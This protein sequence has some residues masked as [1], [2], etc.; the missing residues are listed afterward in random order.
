MTRREKHLAFAGVLTVLF[1][2]SLNMTVVGTALP[3]IIAELEGFNLYAW[4]FTSF[5]L[6]STVSLPIYGRLSDIYGRKGILL[7]GIVVFALASVLSGL[8]QDMLQL[9]AFRALQGVGGGALMS[10]AFATIADIFTPRE[11][12]RYQGFNGA[13]FGVSSVIGPVVGGLITDSLGWRWV[14]FV[15]VPVAVVAFIVITRFL[16]RAE[17][18]RGHAIDFVGSLLLIAGMVPLLLALTW[19]GVDYPWSSPVVVGLLVGAGLALGLFGW[20]QTRT[21]SP[22]L[23]PELFRNATFNIANLAGFMTGVGMFGA[24]IYLPL[25]VQGVQAGS[26]AESG[27]ALAPLMFGMIISSA[28]T[29]ILVSRHGRYKPYIVAGL[30]LMI[31]GLYLASTMGPTTPQLL[32]AVYMVLIGAGLGPANSLLVLA[33][34]NALPPSQL[35]TVTSANQFFRQIGGTIGVTIFGAMITRSLRSGLTAALPPSLRGLPPEAVDQLAD[36]NLLTNPTALEQARSAIE[37]LAGSG[38]FEPFVQAF[39]TALGQGIGQVFLVSLVLTV[40]AFVV[41]LRL[42]QHDLRDEP[43]VVTPAASPPPSEAALRPA[44][45]DG[46]S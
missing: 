45:G 19:G 3:R 7:F 1:L 24:T 18:R 6:A 21:A 34:Q 15:N 35:G 37:A 43:T 22:T 29:G 16:P 38:G 40:V 5:S 4:A 44:K 13:V 10:M 8:S 30:A 27:F 36:P 32:T 41:T 14:F 31:V 39:R 28:L 33:V 12:G 26:A 17:P 11:R 42:P 46:A 2:A 9:I 20:W 25:F 23:A